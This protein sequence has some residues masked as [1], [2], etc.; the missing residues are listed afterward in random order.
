MEV[1]IKFD[2]KGLVPCVVQ[3]VETGEVLMVAY[4]NE[5]SLKKTI[6]TR[7]TWFFSRSRQ[8][9]WQKGETSGNIQEVVDLR[10]DCDEDTLLALVKQKGVACHTGEKSCFFR[11]LISEKPYEK[12]WLSFLKYLEEIVEKRKEALPSDSYTASLI[13]GGLEKVSGKVREESE[14]LIQA[15]QRE[16]KERTI[17][18]AA[19]LMYHLL[20]LFVYQGIKLSEV[21]EKLRERHHSLSS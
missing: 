2:E 10:Y 20:V 7:R 1:K 18:E 12:P 9:L 15:A 4:M 19:D 21:E 3:D 16:G 6:E 13:K 14:E 5:E 11:S 8:K 17:E